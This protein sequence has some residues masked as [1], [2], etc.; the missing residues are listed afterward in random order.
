MKKPLCAALMILSLTGCASII[1]INEFQDG[2]Q[3]VTL[4]WANLKLKDVNGK[5]FDTSHFTHVDNPADPKGYSAITYDPDAGNILA[6]LAT[7]GTLQIKRADSP[8]DDNVPLS[9]PVDTKAYI[10]ETIKC[11]AELQA[12]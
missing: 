8:A 5:P 1:R 2:D 7:G 4:D 6:Y 11:L 9:G 3:L 10:L 12:P